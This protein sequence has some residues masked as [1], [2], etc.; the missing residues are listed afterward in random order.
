MAYSDMITLTLT[1]L[2]TLAGFF[3]LAV[4]IGS[5]ITTDL[6]SMERPVSRGNVS[7]R[8]LN[9]VAVDYQSE[10]ESNHG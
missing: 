3:A 2:F 7:V 10:E 9:Q 8:L 1:I 6:R 4:I 5:L